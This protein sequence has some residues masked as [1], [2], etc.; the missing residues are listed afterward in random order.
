[1]AKTYDSEEIARQI[2]RAIKETGVRLNRW[3]FSPLV[4]LARKKA[5]RDVSPLTIEGAIRMARLPLSLGWGI[6]AGWCGYGIPPEGRWRDRGLYAIGFRAGCRAR[7]LLV[8]AGHKITGF[9]E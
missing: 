7:E 3:G 4:A 6:E 8:Q 9:E 5:G 2:V 1:M